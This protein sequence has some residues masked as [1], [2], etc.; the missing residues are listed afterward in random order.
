MQKAVDRYWHE[1]P[2]EIQKSYGEEYLKDFK[3]SIAN[4]LSRARPSEKIKEVIDDMIDAVA[5]VN[6]K[7]S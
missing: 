2:E 3:T 4:H 6:P 7:V 5:G 1:T